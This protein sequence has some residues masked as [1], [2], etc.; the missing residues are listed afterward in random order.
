MRC[1]N[2]QGTSIG[3]EVNLINAKL[4]NILNSFSVSIIKGIP[5]VPTL[6]SNK[7]PFC[8]WHLLDNSIC[9]FS[10]IYFVLLNLN[11]PLLISLTDRKGIPDSV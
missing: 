6:E 3:I 7:S 10:D 9:S 2:L 11:I 4:T 1:V 5:V 8:G